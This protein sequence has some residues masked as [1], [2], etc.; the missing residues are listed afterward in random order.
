M[1]ESCFVLQTAERGPNGK[2][3]S[4]PGAQRPGQTEVR[5]RAPHPEPSTRP[6]MWGKC[7]I[8]FCYAWVQTVFDGEGSPLAL[9][10]NAGACILTV[11]ENFDRK[12]LQ[13]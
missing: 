4:P 11:I 12:P 3:T 9:K 2:W 5:P 1:K 6:E 10:L 8:C 7:Y 13:L